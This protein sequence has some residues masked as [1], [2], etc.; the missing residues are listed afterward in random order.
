MHASIYFLRLPDIPEDQTTRLCGIH[1]RAGCAN[2]RIS[3]GFIKTA[4][5]VP[6]YAPY[7][8]LNIESGLEPNR[9]KTPIA[10]AIYFMVWPCWRTPPLRQDRATC[11]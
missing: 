5:D 8:S 4:R 2:M 7:A 6:G 1:P 11:P 9:P 3:I 10:Y